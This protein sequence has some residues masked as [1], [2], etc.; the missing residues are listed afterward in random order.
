MVCGGVRVAA[1]ESARSQNPAATMG[2]STNL[3]YASRRCETLFSYLSGKQPLLNDSFAGGSGYYIY[4]EMPYQGRGGTFER[5]LEGL[6]DAA[7]KPLGI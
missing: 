3:R 7:L 5:G 6:L 4:Q 1:A 2:F